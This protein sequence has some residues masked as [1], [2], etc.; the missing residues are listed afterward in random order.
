MAT[1]LT[2][3]AALW[4]SA[5]SLR[6]TEQQYT[7]SERG[8][9]TDRFTKAVEQL[10]S[11]KLDI[12]LGGIYSLEGLAGDSNADRGVIF[13]VL[14]AYVRT[15][16][17]PVDT[18]T[19][20]STPTVDVDAALTVIG[21][22]DQRAGQPERIDLRSTCLA[23]VILTGKNF[24]GVLLDASSLVKAWLPAVSLTNASLQRANLNAA[25]FTD[26][27]LA[28]ANLSMTNLHSARLDHA[29][30]TGA[31][32]YAADLSYANLVGANLA[33]AN[34]GRIVYD[35]TTTW[36]EGFTPPPSRP[37]EDQCGYRNI[38]ACMG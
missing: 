15:H 38:T 3:V 4:F 28:G 8:Q 6:S 21:R 31:N 7:L 32:L 30:L 24:D 9:V 25:K 18:C 2:A 5:Q 13:E 37:R 33:G 26:A 14:S 17:G 11:D 27:D 22:R 35:A 19:A 29:E 20:S 12:R 16:A 23:N 34:L 1:A 36:P 10:G